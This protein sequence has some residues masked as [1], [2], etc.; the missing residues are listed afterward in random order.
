MPA[1]KD[2]KRIIRTRMQKTGESYTAA[3][4][5]VVK[6]SPS[7][8]NNP[9]IAS[10]VNAPA[11]ADFEALA[12]MSDESVKKATG[13]DWARWV[14]ELDRH[15][16]SAMSHGDIVRLVSN[17]W[18][19][20]S[21][22]SQMVTVG[23]ERIRGLRQKGQSREGSFR[24]T[25]SKTITAPASE[26]FQAWRNARARAKW[27]P[28]V[29][30]TVRT[31]IAARSLRMRWEDDTPVAVA[32]YP[33]ALG[34]YRVSVEHQKLASREDVDRLKAFWKQALAAL[35]ARWKATD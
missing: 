7:T 20:G 26:I 24:V 34:K 25:T 14:R 1:Q 17:S 30:L 5:H 9:D 31:A 3:R 33:L 15:G 19:T 6:P 11:P 21:W 13:C 12:G 35:A 27:L 23:Y 4:L 2:L 22:W 32:I 18:N 28:G 29:K 10:A 16:A 8:K